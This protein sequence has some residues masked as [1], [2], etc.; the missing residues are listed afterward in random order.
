MHDGGYHSMSNPVQGFHNLLIK[1][2]MGL[3]E[4]KVL[5]TTIPVVEED[6]VVGLDPIKTLKVCTVLYLQHHIPTK[7]F[8]VP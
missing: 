1:M 6:L 4:S 7:F 5:G 8:D 3:L 2:K